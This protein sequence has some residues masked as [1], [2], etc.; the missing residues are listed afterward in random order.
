L[1]INTEEFWE[2]IDADEMADLDVPA[3][4]NYVLKSS[5]SPKMHWVGHS[6]GGGI[7]V[8]ALAEHP[9]LQKKLGKVVLLAPGVHMHDIKVPLL[10]SMSNR[11]IDE[12]WYNATYI[13]D[14]RGM[15]THRY[16][17]AGPRF[18]QL[19]HFF[20]AFTPLCRLSVSLCNNIGK[21]LG[22]N[23]GDSQNLDPKTMADAYSFDPGGASFHL[24]MHWAQRV[25]VDEISHFDWGS[26]ENPKHYNG[27]V[28]APLYDLSKIR[29]VEF[30][31]YDGG[32]DLFITPPSVR[33]L[34]SEIGDYNSVQHTTFAEYAHMDFVWGRNAHEVLYPDVLRFLQTSSDVRTPLIV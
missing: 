18:Q 6:Q 11:H 27:S 8:Q 9:E 14:I 29:N 2:K 4:L 24:L 32:K 1:N 26:S 10:K 13:P 22:I 15:A 3:I 20:T 19:M 17:F 31:L 5:V 16:Y 12:W 28:S 23:V 30:A 25:R 7:I 34:L 21:V 33:S